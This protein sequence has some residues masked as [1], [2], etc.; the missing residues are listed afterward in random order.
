[1]RTAYIVIVI[2]FLLFVIMIE[3]PEPSPGLCSNQRLSAP[4]TDA[5]SNEGIRNLRSN[6]KSEDNANNFKP[7][8]HKIR[9][10]SKEKKK[11]EPPK[12]YRSRPEGVPV[13]RYASV[14]DNVRLDSTG[15]K[16]NHRAPAP[17]RK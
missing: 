14:M 13:F 7:S 12:K 2:W 9:V 8:N 10:W 1:M 3:K 15:N 11:W 6:I 16:L 5:D 17:L 4:V